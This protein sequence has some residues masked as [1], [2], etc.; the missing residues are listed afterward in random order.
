MKN[1]I[2]ICKDFGLEIPSEKVDEFNKAVAENY[3]TVSDYQKQVDKAAR[4]KTRADTAEETLKG[5]DGKDY[6]A[7][8]AERD[9]W[10]RKCTE[11]EE[12]YRRENE[13][14]EFNDIVSSSITEAKGKNAKAIAALLDLDNL[15]KSKNQKAD[16]AAALET[17]KTENGYLFEDEGGKAHFTEPSKG[18]NPGGGAK[19]DLG[20]LSMADYIAA[21]KK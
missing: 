8:I 2:D 15:R 21:R 14:R 20:K 10:Q 16:V 7:I 9:E 6:D 4:E 3:K 11:N 13:E 1:I 12:K 19:P 18:G 17:V 5:F